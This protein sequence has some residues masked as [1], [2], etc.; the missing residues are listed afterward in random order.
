MSRKVAFVTGASRGIGKAC[1]VHLAKAG[2]DVAITARTLHDGE[3]REHSPTVKHSD[4]SPL[5]GSLDQ[6]AA[7][8]R[9]TGRE[10]LAVAADITDAASLGHAAAT[11]LGQVNG[12]QL[13]RERLDLN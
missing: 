1:A 2:Y 10:A 3:A 6:T 12:L 4:M 8:V 9:A 5:P 11:V 13:P 7:A